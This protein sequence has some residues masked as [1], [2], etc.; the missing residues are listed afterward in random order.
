[1]RGTIM[2]RIQILPLPTEKVGDMEHTPFILILDQFGEEE[3][4]EP[5]YGET[6][7]GQTGA[8]TVLAYRGTMD[9]PDSLDLTEEQRKRLVDYLLFPRRWVTDQRYTEQE[10]RLIPGRIMST[11]DL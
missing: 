6:L 4:W 3:A 10:A 8:V 11:P 1:M 9:A 7:K 2:A 5:A